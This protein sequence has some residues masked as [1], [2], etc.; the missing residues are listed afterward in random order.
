MTFIDDE[1]DRILTAQDEYEDDEELKTVF[2]EIEPEPEEDEDEVIPQNKVGYEVSSQIIEEPTKGLYPQEIREEMKNSFLDYAMSVIVSRALPDVRD[3]LKPVH[4]RILHGMNELGITYSS[5][6]KKSARIVGDVL[7]KYHPHGDTSVYEAMVRLAQ[8]FSLRYPLID[9]HGNFGSIDG[10]PAAA[11][12]YT[13]ARMSKIAAEMLDGIKKNT[14]DFMDNYDA[15]EIE[16][17]VLPSRYPNILVTG[18]TGIAVGMATAIPPHNLTET[19]DATI[20]LARNKEITIEELMTYIKGPDFPTGAEILGSKGIA[21]MYTTG[22]GSIPVRS[23]AKIEQLASGKSKIIITEIPFELKKTTIIE[24]IADLVKN[25]IVEGIIDLRDESNKDGIRIVIIVKKNVYANIVLNQ[26]YR[27]TPLQSNY[28]ANIVA[29]V[30]GEPKQLNLKQILV[31]YL[32]HQYEVV[33][34]RLQFDL[35]KNEARLLILEGLKIAVDNIDEVVQTIRKSSNDADAIAKLTQRFKLVEVQAKA[36]VDMRLG[37][38]TGLAVDKMNEE[39]QQLNIEIKKIKEI[40]NSHDLLTNLIIDELT[41]IRDKYGDKRRS[42]IN[43][44]ASIFI[45]DEDLVSQREIVISLSSKGY[46]K[47]T[48]LSEYRAQK[49]G[50][51]GIQGMKTYK[52]DDLEQL[53]ITNSHIDLLI[54]TSLGRIYRI[55]ALEIPEQSRQSKGTPFVNIIDL[56]DQERVVSVISTDSYDADKYLVTV[57]KL[58]M[59]KKTHISEYKHI[60]RNGKIALGL[61]EGDEVIRAMIVKNTEDIIIASSAGKLVRFNLMD[62]R[63]VGRIAK[64]VIAVKLDDNAFVVS[65]SYSSEGNYILSLGQFGYGK[66]TES[67]SY[68]KTKRGA[69][70]VSCI[71]SDKA[72]ELIGCRYIN[73]NEDLILINDKGVTIRINASELPEIGR[74]AKGVKVIKL[75][76]NEFLKA[77]EVVDNKSIEEEAEIEYQKTQEIALENNN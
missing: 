27:L 24:K 31:H 74:S 34:R 28:S 43:E 7:G 75:K 44:N 11:M 4:R 39:I 40:L 3:G 52:D 38:L 1:K 5:A 61:K 49:R 71:N 16:P 66:K 21:D 12:R 25:K 10:D 56:M 29:L 76:K 14:V 63:S 46:V 59:I 36:I 60:N 72:G 54:F 33:T 17:V 53:L 37:R 35:E 70:G 67:E 77:F 9:G 47:R 19:I 55:R 45:S 62:V 51:V 18:A 48:D 42:F 6:H 58:G 69:K 73:G 2:Q 30:N 32:D 23:K 15:S 68:R 22:R 57:S 20:A 13:E 26:L 41:S 8:D 50:G 65:A 64:G